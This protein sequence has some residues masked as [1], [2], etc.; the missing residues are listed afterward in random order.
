MPPRKQQ[1]FR[2]PI[3]ADFFQ[4]M[5]ISHPTPW[6]IAVAASNHGAAIQTKLKCASTWAEI[7]GFGIV[8]DVLY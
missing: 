2:P 3:L 6:N 1:F 4:D 8:L 7:L 5:S